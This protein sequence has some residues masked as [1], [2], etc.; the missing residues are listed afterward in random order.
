MQDVRIDTPR[1]EVRD[2]QE[3]AIS[4]LFH[5]FFKISEP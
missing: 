1:V 5:K 4:H 2:L 3:R